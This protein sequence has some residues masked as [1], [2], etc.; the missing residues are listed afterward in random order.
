MIPASICWMSRFSGRLTRSSRETPLRA[1]ALREEVEDVGL[2]MDWRHEPRAG[3]EE[4][5]PLRVREVVFFLHEMLAIHRNF[6]S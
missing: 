2:E 3:T 5:A 6:Q 1:R 4:F